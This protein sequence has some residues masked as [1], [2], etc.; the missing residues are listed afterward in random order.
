METKNPV[1]S[2]KI[3]LA[4]DLSVGNRQSVPMPQRNDSFRMTYVIVTYTTKTFFNRLLFVL[5]NKL[6]TQIIY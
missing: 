5:T 6:E 1:V 4:T 2:L 3:V